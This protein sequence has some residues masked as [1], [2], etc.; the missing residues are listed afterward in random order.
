MV[1]L[2]CWKPFGM[3]PGAIG[4]LPIT[5]R[6]AA[7]EQKT[8]T[9]FMPICIAWK[10]IRSMQVTGTDV[11]VLRYLKEVSKKNGPILRSYF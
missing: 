10:A 9:A 1:F 11:L 2:S 5:L 3:M 8:M 4:K 7:K 6:K